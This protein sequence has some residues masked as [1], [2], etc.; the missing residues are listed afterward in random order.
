[1]FLSLSHFHLHLYLPKPKKI[2]LFIYFYHPIKG[3]YLR[4]WFYCFLCP[5][6]DILILVFH[7][8]LTRTLGTKTKQ[9]LRKLLSKNVIQSFVNQSPFYPFIHQKYEH[10]SFSPWYMSRSLYSFHMMNILVFIFRHKIYNKNDHKWDY[11]THT[12]RCSSWT[13]YVIGIRKVDEK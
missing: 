1:M 8:P 13:E 6:T 11:H 12:F 4:I 9:H 2:K 5:F 10:M 3:D 7:Y